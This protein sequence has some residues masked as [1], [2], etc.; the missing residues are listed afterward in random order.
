[1]ETRTLGARSPVISVVGY[2]AWEA[3][4]DLWGPNE[5]D[6]RVVE[7]IHAA[8]DA[9][10]TWIDTAEIYGHGRSEELVGRALAEGRGDVLVF[11]KVAPRPSGTGFRPQEVRR[12]LD[13]SLKRLGAQYVDLY[14]LHWPDRSVPIEDTWGAMAAL[15]DEGLARH[16]GLSNVDRRLVERCEAIRHVDSVQNEFSLLQRGDRNEL[17]PWLVEQRTGYLAYSPLGLGMLSGAISADHRFDQ[18]DF[19]SGAQGSPPRYFRRD[20]LERNTRKVERLREVAS[21][22]GATVASLALRWV[23]EQPGVTGAIAGSRNPDHVRENASAGDL[24]LD[25]ATL[26]EIDAI[27]R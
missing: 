24:R 23:L 26:G 16:L 7:A 1:M 12:A 22:A 18:R 13:A 5:S 27:F 11:T 2:G 4:G 15:Q 3:G 14:Q 20:A 8:L 21:R 19:R 6:E 9:G 17:L 10:M 25:P